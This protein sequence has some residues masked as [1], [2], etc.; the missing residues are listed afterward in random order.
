MCIIPTT[1]TIYKNPRR[2]CE[3]F[4]LPVVYV[5]ISTYLSAVLDQKTKPFLENVSF[6]Q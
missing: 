3:G 6:R 2:V 4:L 5:Y 1:G